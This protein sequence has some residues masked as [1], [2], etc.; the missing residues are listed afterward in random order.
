MSRISD[1]AKTSYRYL[2]QDPELSLCRYYSLK[3]RG[4]ASRISQTQS[5]LFYHPWCRYTIS[6]SVKTN[7]I[8]A[9]ISERTLSQFFKMTSNQGKVRVIWPRELANSQ[10]ICFYGE[11]RL[12]GQVQDSR[13]PI[14][15]LHGILDLCCELRTDRKWSRTRTTV[16]SLWTFSCVGIVS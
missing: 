16:D 12:V 14:H 15:D 7:S 5:I 11:L 2:W 9:A 4:L 3:W 8:F 6:S 10:V 13:F 1:V